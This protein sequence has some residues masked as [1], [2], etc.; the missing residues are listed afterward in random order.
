VYNDI[1]LIENAEAN[2]ENDINSNEDG[3][4]TDKVW[5]GNKIPKE[6]LENLNQNKGDINN[7]NNNFADFWNGDIEE[8]VNIDEYVYIDEYVLLVD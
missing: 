2:F 8:Y 7:R 6:F 3:W 1:D 4:V 5:T